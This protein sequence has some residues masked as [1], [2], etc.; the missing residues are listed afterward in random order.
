[1]RIGSCF[2]LVGFGGMSA[3][4]VL[5]CIIGKGELSEGVRAVVGDDDGGAL[6][7]R[8]L[9]GKCVV[10]WRIRLHSSLRQR[11][12]LADKEGVIA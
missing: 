4:V 3:S 2:R 8:R 9:I 6:I 11:L 7:G 12:S 5:R 10:L 1:M